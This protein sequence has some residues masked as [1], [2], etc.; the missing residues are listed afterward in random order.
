MPFPVAMRES[1]Q[2]ELIIKNTSIEF[3]ITTLIVLKVIN[4]NW[5]Q[6]QLKVTS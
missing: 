3:R 6:R 5:R 2:L 1:D 4:R